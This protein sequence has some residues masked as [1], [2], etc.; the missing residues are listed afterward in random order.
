MSGPPCTRGSAW[1]SPS[2]LVVR[3]ATGP[4]TGSLT[5]PLSH[6]RSHGPPSPVGRIHRGRPT[7]IDWTHIPQRSNPPRWAPHSDAG[8]AEVASWNAMTE[9]RLNAHPVHV[10]L[11]FS[12]QLCTI[13]QQREVWR[14]ADEAGFDHLWDFDHFHP[15]GGAPLEGDMFDGWS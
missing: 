12:Q 11:K 13:Q 2:R 10:G 14:I 3:S 9:A 6:S 5:K 15:I 4:R 8:A 7:W 1:P